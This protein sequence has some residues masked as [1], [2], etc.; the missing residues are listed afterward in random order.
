M[1]AGIRAKLSSFTLGVLTADFAD[2]AD[3]GKE[4]CAISVICGGVPRSAFRMGNLSR[5]N[6][7]KADGNSFPE[8]SWGWTIGANEF[9][10]KTRRRKAAKRHRKLAGDNVPGECEKWTRRGATMENAR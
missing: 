8:F 10:A 3:A 2:D 4:I 6:Q 7:M 9:N 5:R 1:K